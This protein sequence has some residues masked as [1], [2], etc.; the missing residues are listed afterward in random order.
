[1][2]EDKDDLRRLWEQRKEQ[3]RQAAR[4]AVEQHIAERNAQARRDAKMDDAFERELSGILG[5][6]FEDIQRSISKPGDDDVTAVMAEYN[7]QMR[8]GRPDK[9]KKV[10]KQNKKIVKSHVQKNKRGCSSVL[11]VLIGTGAT[12]VSAATW[13]AIEIVS[14]IVQ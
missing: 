3:E 8:K 7:R 14:A 2:G 6:S 4:D 9:A 5:E 10:I 12:L 11:L 1:M 13:G